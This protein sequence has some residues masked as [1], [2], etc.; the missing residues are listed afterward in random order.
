VLLVDDD[1]QVPESPTD[2][3]KALLD[4]VAPEVLL[5]IDEAIV[6]AAG[7][8]WLKVARI[9]FDAIK[10]GGF[11]TVDEQVQLHVRRMIA[12]VRAGRLE[13]QGNLLR[14]RFSEIRLPSSAQ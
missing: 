3:E 6:A 10:A 7:S 8:R 4:S 11:S 1:E 2:R 14:P 12:L 5:A 9:V 13:A